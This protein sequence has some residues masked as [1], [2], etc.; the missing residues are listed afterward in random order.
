MSAAS[1]CRTAST[2]EFTDPGDG[3]LDVVAV[4]STPR[5]EAFATSRV[6]E[7]NVEIGGIVGDRHYGITRPSNSRQARF[8]PRGTK[9][10]NRRQVS[11]V[12]VE[13][14]DDVARRMRLPQVRAEE[15]GANVL[16][17]GIADFSALPIGTRLLFDGGL[18]LVCEGV[19]QPCRLPAQLLQERHPD[20]DA[21]KRF[22][23]EAFG[24]R[25]IVA[26]VEHPGVLAGGARGRLFLPETHNTLT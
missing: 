23:R 4:L 5:P 7:L 17:S 25:G 14:L 13:E 12:A 24:R 9:I 8:Y 20:S 3:A 16:V 1:I 15:L 19:N 6:P 2:E 10:R 18:G 11:L 21:A 26:S 22:V